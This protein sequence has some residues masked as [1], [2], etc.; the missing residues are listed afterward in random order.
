MARG[1]KYSANRAREQLH[2][3]FKWLYARDRVPTNIMDKVAKVLFD[4][5]AGFLN[6]PPGQALGAPLLRQLGGVLYRLRVGLLG[7]VSVPG[8]G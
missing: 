2:T 6:F 5:F 4:G 8:L 3:F 1:K 7:G